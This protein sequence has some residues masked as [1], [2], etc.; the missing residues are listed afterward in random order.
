M[1]QSG[2]QSP[3]RTSS[4]SIPF[5]NCTLNNRHTKFWCWTKYNKTSHRQREICVCVCGGLLCMCVPMS[6]FWIRSFKMNKLLQLKGSICTLCWEIK[7]SLPSVSFFK[8]N[9]LQ[10]YENGVCVCQTAPFRFRLLCSPPPKAELP[11]RPKGKLKRVKACCL[12]P[13]PSKGVKQTSFI[14]PPFLLQLTSRPMKFNATSGGGRK[15]G[16][17]CVRVGEE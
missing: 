8:D 9:K 4:E 17:V 1:G 6:E 3:S 11:R 16:Q 12:S 15:K 13:P 2:I 10:R 7:T 14:D 5:D